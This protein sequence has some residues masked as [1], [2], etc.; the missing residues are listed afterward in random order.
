[1]PVYMQM[2]TIRSET[3]AP[4]SDGT[5]NTLMAAEQYGPSEPDDET[6]VAPAGGDAVHHDFKTIKVLDKTSP[7]LLDENG[8]EGDDFIVGSFGSKDTAEDANSGQQHYSFR[9]WTDYS[10][11][12]SIWTDMGAPVLRSAD[13]RDVD[14]AGIAWVSGDGGTRGAEPPPDADW[15]LL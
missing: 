4:L 9:W 15:L 12:D 10:G 7:L 8:G 13:G 11:T 6:L 3:K 5:S 1:M 14:G 2:D